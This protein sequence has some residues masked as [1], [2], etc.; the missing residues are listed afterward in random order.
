M[1]LDPFRV[2]GRKTPEKLRRDH[3]EKH[4]GVL[5]DKNLP[6]V[7]SL[8]DNFQKEGINNSLFEEWRRCIAEE[9]LL[10]NACGLPVPNDW[11][12]LF[13][14]IS[15]FGSEIL[16]GDCINKEAACAVFPLRTQ[17][18]PGIGH[19]WVI[20]GLRYQEEKPGFE[21]LS[22]DRHGLCFTTT[23]SEWK[24]GRSWLLAGYLARY[25]CEENK[26]NNIIKSLAIQ[27]MITGDV[28][29]DK[30]VRVELGNKLQR[31]AGSTRTWLIPRDNARE[32]GP[33]MEEKL[34]IRSAPNV[35]TA[36]N[37]VSG[38]G[39][40]EGEEQRW[41]EDIDELH[42][43]TGGNIKAAIASVLLTT[44]L[45]KVV[46]WQSENEEASRKPAR[47]LQRI[48]K[49]YRPEMQC[50]LENLTSAHLAEAERT[51]RAY[52]SESQ[53]N[54]LLFNVTSGNRLMSYAVQN[55]ARLH[56]NI[57]L[58]YRDADAE[59]FEFTWF[60]YTQFPAVS[61]IYKGIPPK[62]YS[63]NWK[64]LF[65]GGKP[66]QG[67]SDYELYLAYFQEMKDSSV[68]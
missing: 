46:I 7:V 17:G 45:N 31:P 56:P 16:L 1:L 24:Y 22:D 20:I 62:A 40:K 25:A 53:S 54:P 44:G 14:Q 13:K 18:K 35:E 63:I 34:I 5:L 23:E 49:Q 30:V 51:L 50:V 59:D 28:Q 2:A 33:A 55:L 38:Q 47:A 68:L 10:R 42:I 39:T 9:L 57:I 26:Q 48:V 29:D 27:W 64:F 8:L 60:D 11:Y 21:E 61:G 37:H 67:D 41:P 36:W 58:I 15:P 66:P 32:V 19:V 3:L 65:T 43:L 4:F 52:F 12:E 6:E